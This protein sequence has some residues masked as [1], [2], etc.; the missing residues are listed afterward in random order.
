MKK[1]WLGAILLLLAIGLLSCTPSEPIN[2]TPAFDFIV[3]KDPEKD[4]VLLVLSDPQVLT[5][6]WS[7]SGSC[8]ET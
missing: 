1:I 5:E 6:W 8:T 3:E 2:G 4:F 7:A